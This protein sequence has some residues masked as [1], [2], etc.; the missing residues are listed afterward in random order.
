VDKHG[1]VLFVSGTG[2]PVVCSFPGPV[3]GKDMI[4]AFW[5]SAVTLSDLPVLDFSE[6][7]DS[8]A[9]FLLGEA[10]DIF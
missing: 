6:Q 1:R 5:T 10:L 7:P 9:E 3:I 2:S 8:D 4:T